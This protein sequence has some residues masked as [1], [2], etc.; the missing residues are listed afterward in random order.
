M[1]TCSKC[2]LEKE[3]NQ[4]YTYWH[5]TQQTYRTRKICNT[6]MNEQ[7]K[8]YISKIRQE[9]IKVEQVII[10][11]E[12]VSTIKQEL[13][14]DLFKN[15]PLYKFCKGCNTYKLIETEYYLYGPNRRPQTVCKICHNAYSKQ[16]SNE[17]HQERY[18][19]NG[20]SLEIIPKPNCY[21]DIYQKEQTFWL[22]NLLGWTFDEELG[23]W[24]K[25]G[26]KDKF[27]NWVNV[28]KKVKP[29]KPKRKI[30]DIN[31]IIELKRRGYNLKEI[32]EELNYSVITVR[33]YLKIYN[34]NLK[35]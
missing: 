12:K 34:N 19:N 4:Y 7:K 8:R 22:M 25:D 3:E 6:C 13:E 18:K 23:I 1:K 15:N 28:K 11:E 5:S 26:I 30:I 21:K 31:Q 32:S 24:W 16:R 27:N 33:K 10:P 29:E 17:Y 35:K 2:K 9:K 14:I 20:G